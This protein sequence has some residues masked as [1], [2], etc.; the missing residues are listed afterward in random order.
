MPWRD[1]AANLLRSRD[2]DFADADENLASQHVT[3][4][5]QTSP[6]ELNAQNAAFS[7]YDNQDNSVEASDASAFV[8]LD[9]LG[10]W[11]YDIG[12]YEEDNSVEASEAS[13]LSISDSFPDLLPVDDEASMNETSD[14]SEVSVNEV[15]GSLPT[16]LSSDDEASVNEASGS[17]TAIVSSDVEAANGQPPLFFI[18]YVANSKGASKSPFSSPS[19]EF[20][21]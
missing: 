18:V 20:R 5:I 17:L 7:L 6:S 8:T 21:L 4:G 13:T 9:A 2:S 11:L 1:I 12:L 10:A 15:S 16:V 14:L 3:F 19:S